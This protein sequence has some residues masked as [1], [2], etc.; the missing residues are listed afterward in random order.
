MVSQADHG[1]ASL[2]QARGGFNKLRLPKGFRQNTNV[3]EGF[4]KRFSPIASDEHERHVPARQRHSDLI[5]GLPM[6]IAV[7]K[8]CI[9]L[10]TLDRRERFLGGPE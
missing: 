4:R 6:Q 10:P 9:H 1:I 7:E 8:R 5:D 2:N 3:S